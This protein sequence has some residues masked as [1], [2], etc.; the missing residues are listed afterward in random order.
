MGFFRGGGGI[1]RRLVFFGVRGGR[2]KGY[3]KGG[4]GET[5]AQREM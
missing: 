4:R 2:K 3:D 5:D 1:G